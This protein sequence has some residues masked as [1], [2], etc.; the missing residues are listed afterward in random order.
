MQIKK[1]LIS[2]L[3]LL[4]GLSVSA[5]SN[6][7]VEVSYDR[8]VIH[9]DSLALPSSIN[10]GALLRLLPELLARP[11]DNTLSN[12]EVQID[13]VSVGEAA[14][15]VLSIVQLEDVKRLEVNN[16]PTMSDL[17]NGQSGSINIWLR[18]L[19]SK[20]QGVSGT[21]SL[22]ASGRSMVARVG[23]HGMFTFTLADR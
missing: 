4:V 3:C 13:G 2:A 10:V 7:I 20:P 9:T 16:S 15:D 17:N 14:D 19:A 6:T 21:T 22:G 8:K 23:V 5:Q 18:P 12:Y 11:G 1:Y